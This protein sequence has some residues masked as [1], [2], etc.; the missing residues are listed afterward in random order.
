MPNFQK[1]PE[2]DAPLFGKTNAERELKVDPALE[3]LQTN[4]F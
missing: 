2:L 4:I 3:D 1:P